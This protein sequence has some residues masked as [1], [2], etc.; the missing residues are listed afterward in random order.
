MQIGVYQVKMRSL[1]QIKA[2]LTYPEFHVD[3]EAKGDNSIGMQLTKVV[4][5][6]E[7]MFTNSTRVLF[8]ELTTIGNIS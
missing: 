1:L 3:S 5:S 7:E 8:G 4:K 6:F 2:K